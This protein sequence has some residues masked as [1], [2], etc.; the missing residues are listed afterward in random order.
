MHSC[1]KRK[2]ND[3]MKVFCFVVSQIHGDPHQQCTTKT[4]RKNQC[5]FTDS[6]LFMNS[7]VFIDDHHQT[8]DTID[9]K[10]Q[11]KDSFHL[12]SPF[13]KSISHSSRFSSI[14][15]NNLSGGNKN[16]K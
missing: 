12:F 10:P 3:K 9:D 16:E 4:T 5:S 14:L 8:S 7:I 6:F 15:V 13:L 11:Q 1:K 2:A